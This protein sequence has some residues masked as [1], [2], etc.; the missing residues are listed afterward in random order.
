MKST[1]S[2]ISLFA[3]LV[4]ICFCFS[5]C[6]YSGYMF[7]YQGESA[8]KTKTGVFSQQTKRIEIDNQFGDVHIEAINGEGDWIWTGKCW[9][10]EKAD[11]EEFL[12]QLEM[13]VTEEG[14]TQK[15]TVVMPESN[16]DLRGV[17]SDLTIKVHPDVLVVVKN[18]HGNQ[19][20]QAMT[21]E[22]TLENAH[23]NIETVKLAGKTSIVNQHG[24][25]VITDHHGRT[26]VDA[27]HGKLRVDGAGAALQIHCEHVDVVVSDANGI[28]DSVVKHGNIDVSC[29]GT[30][31][32]IQLKH[33][34]AKITLAN[35][36]FESLSIDAEHG[37]VNVYLP[38][39]CKPKVQARVEHG[40]IQ[41][42]FENSGA[43][44]A[45]KVESNSKHGNLKV[46]KN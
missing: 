44:D 4:S 42:E 37:N 21:G 1:Y 18:K 5:G 20:I 3:L 13:E 46:H 12:K 27:K 28:V 8:S 19:N 23:G 15:W 35:P 24:D 14:D 6:Q 10:T 25:I 43:A 11:A 34:N 40:S 31:Q 29:F 36:E 39:S 22:V 9:A 33:G 16:T 32:S 17:R 2:Q 41:N 26:S 7:D 30:T 38:S 45:P